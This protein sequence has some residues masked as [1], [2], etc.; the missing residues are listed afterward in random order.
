[1]SKQEWKPGTILYP[2]PAV[3]VSCGTMDKS[4]II[5]I[6]WTGTVNTD[7]AMTYISV[8]PER[9]SY[10]IIKESGEFVINVTTEELAFATDWCGVRSGAQYDKFKEMKLT[11]GKG[12]H[13]SCP[14]IEESPI[15]IECK[16]VKEL[17]LGSHTMFLAE[18]VGVQADEKFMEESGRFDFAASNPIAYSHGEYYT[19]GKKLG[20]FGY[21]V[22]KN[23]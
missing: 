19:L 21:S 12:L 17:P 9:H 18:I 5:T 4:N 11:K 23:K 2:I 6:A 7:P 14:I 1:M 15:N 22:K 8:R 13:V 16:V 20:K 3:M 10:N